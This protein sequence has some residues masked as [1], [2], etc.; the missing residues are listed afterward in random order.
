MLRIWKF[1][2]VLWE[3]KLRIEWGSVFLWGYDGDLGG[4]NGAGTV[5]VECKGEGRRWG[6]IS[7][8]KLH[9]CPP[10]LRPKL[11]SWLHPSP[12]HLATACEVCFEVRLAYK[13]KHYRLLV[14]QL[15]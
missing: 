2:N 9:S 13:Y 8:L 3:G 10:K 11:L 7:G 1:S 12:G 5:R 6:S 14:T 4:I 15:F